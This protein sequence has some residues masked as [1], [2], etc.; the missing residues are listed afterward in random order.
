MSKLFVLGSGF[1]KAVSETMPIMSDL[2]EYVRHRIDALPGGQD[3]RRIYENLV[4]DVEALMTYLYT[5]MPWKDVRETHL[6]RAA[7]VVVSRLVS[8]C[9][10][11]SEEGGLEDDYPD[12]F[13]QLVKYL[14]NGQLT[15]AT[16]NY[17]TIFERQWLELWKDDGPQRY[18]NID[19]L[20]LMPL[21]STHDRIVT[22]LGST[23][24]ETC[25]LLKLHGSI[26][27]YFAGDE[28]VPGQQVYYKSLKSAD[29]LAED[30]PEKRQ[31]ELREKRDILDLVPLII[32][33]IAEKTSFYGTR[34]VMALWK[35]LKD[36]ID[37][38]SE[39][40]FVG[41]SLPK[42]DLTTRLFFSSVVGKDSDKAIYIVDCATRK[43][44]CNLIENYSSIF[45]RDN[46]NLDYLGDDNAI[47]QMVGSLTNSDE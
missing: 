1:S 18:W 20:Y 28:N 36:G 11:E 7:F 25:R 21:R 27:W 2:A 45:G 30:T 42:T 9:V 6:D 26:N 24:V 33:P 22:T 14:H 38:A 32:P 39:I 10:S 16:F 47:E 41:Y 23:P 17:D 40:Y 31:R 43:A 12:W 19:S 29:D 46:L 8:D 5:A 3:D 44:R 4:S 13:R 34:L 35:E 37:K 15:V